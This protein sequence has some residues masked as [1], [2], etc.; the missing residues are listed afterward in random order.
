MHQSEPRSTSQENELEPPLPALLKDMQDCRTAGLKLIISDYLVNYELVWAGLGGLT[1]ET[2]TAAIN[3]RETEALG[4][5]A[6][7]TPLVY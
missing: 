5:P 7:A 3:K 2:V 6:G 1:R 4:F